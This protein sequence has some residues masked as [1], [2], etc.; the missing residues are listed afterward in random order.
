MISELERTPILSIHTLAFKIVIELVIEKKTNLRKKQI[1]VITYSG[2]V[3][4]ISEL[5]AA[6][7]VILERE[8]PPAPPLNLHSLGVMFLGQGMRQMFDAILLVQL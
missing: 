6:G 3:S 2:L 1:N 8:A 5:M 7:H 4:F